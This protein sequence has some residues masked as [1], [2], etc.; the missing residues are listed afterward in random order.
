[1]LF[2]KRRSHNQHSTDDSQGKAITKGQHNLPGNKAHTMY[3]DNGLS[4]TII[5]DNV[6]KEDWSLSVT[7][8]FKSMVTFWEL[9]EKLDEKKCTKASKTSCRVKTSLGLSPQ[10]EGESWSLE[11]LGLLRACQ[12]NAWAAVGTS[13]YSDFPLGLQYIPWWKILA[14]LRI[15]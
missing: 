13:P 7:Y 5:E 1:M 14:R 2:W 8:V 9:A 3:V 10:R 11:R 6:G 12:S 4:K 15:S